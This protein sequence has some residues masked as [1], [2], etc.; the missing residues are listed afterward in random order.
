MSI[1]NLYLIQN[2]LPP[3]ITVPSSLSLIFV[4]LVPICFVAFATV[5]GAALRPSMSRELRLDDD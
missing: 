5:T 1:S 2:A 4:A 3:H